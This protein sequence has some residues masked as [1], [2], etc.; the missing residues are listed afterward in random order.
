MDMLITM[1]SNVG[2]GK[3]TRHLADLFFFYFFFFSFVSFYSHTHTTAPSRQQ[4]HARAFHTF[5]R[6]REIGMKRNYKE[7]TLV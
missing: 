5:L 3:R 7:I 1:P 6:F 2:A 4:S